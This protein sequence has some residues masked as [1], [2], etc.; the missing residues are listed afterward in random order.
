[1]KH[2]KKTHKSSSTKWAAVAFRSC[3]ISCFIF[4][5]GISNSFAQDADAPDAPSGGAATSTA[6]TAT[7]IK[8][9][10]NFYQVL[11]E[12]LSDFD[13]DLKTG[14]VIGL[15]DL[16]IR[17][18]ATSEN[19]PASF[20]SHLELIISERILKNTKT[21]IVHCVSCRS[22]KAKLSGDSMVVSSSDNNPAEQTRMA[23]LNGIQN[24]MDVAFAYQPNGMILSLQISDSDTGTMLWSRSYNSE[25]TRAAA[26]K[27]GVDYKDLDQAS[28]KMEYQPTVQMRPTLYVGMLP[29]ASG[30]VTALGFGF[31]MMERYDNRKKE[32]GFEMIYNYDVN[33][34]TGNTAAT[35]DKSNVYNGV[36][37]TLLFTHAWSLFGEVENYN[38]PRGTIFGQIG[39]TYA[40][41]F[42]G[43]VI[44][45]GYEWRF[46]KHWVLP[47]FLGY[48]PSGTVVIP[49]GNQTISGIEGGIG[50]GYLF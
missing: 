31:R 33:S 22:K 39:G 25:N 19:V 18:I 3:I 5:Q 2:Y 24:F 17:N 44:R 20:K 9:A 34:L 50:V 16:S 4:A 37:I 32:V 38:Q 48:R 43:A 13:Y 45:G 7:T 21:R 1:M 28:T 14:Q 27:Q 40:S 35:I 8:G 36:N 26:Q 23:K 29:K 6:P 30:Y 15:K 47:V 11:D 41:G 12:I 10:R 42:L 46:A 49:T